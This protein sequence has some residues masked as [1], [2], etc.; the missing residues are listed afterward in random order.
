MP[1]RSG[2]TDPAEL[3]NIAPQGEQHVALEPTIPRGG[4]APGEREGETGPGD[5]LGVLLA[6]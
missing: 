1:E 4:G 5:A 6:S 3:A 2:P